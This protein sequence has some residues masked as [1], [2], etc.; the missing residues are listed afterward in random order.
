MPCRVPRLTIYR[1]SVQLSRCRRPAKR[2]VLA[3]SEDDAARAFRNA[4]PSA[5]ILTTTAHSTLDLVAPMVTQHIG[6]A[7][8]FHLLET[9]AI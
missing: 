7:Q 3:L 2:L 4:F 5:R 9:H 8:L 6:R 1:L